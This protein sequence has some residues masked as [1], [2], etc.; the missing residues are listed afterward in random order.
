MAGESILPKKMNSMLEQSGQ[1]SLKRVLGLRHL[2][3]YGIAFMTPI[4]PAYIY[5]YVSSM[6]GGMMALA[7]CV[8]MVA[9]LFTASSYGKMSAAFPS[10]GSTYSYTQ[11]AL[12]PDIGFMAGWAMY[13]DY[14]LV[15]L[16]VLMMGATYANTLL[17]FIPYQIWVLILAA[18]VFT[19]NFRGIGF[20][21]KANNI[22]VIYMGAIV[23]V[24]VLLGIKALI[25]G[26]GAATLISAKPF[27]N[28]GTFTTSAIVSGAALASFSFLGFDSITTLS[29]EAIRPKK[30]IGRAAMLSCLIGGLIFIIQVYIAQLVWPDYNAFHSV[31][32]AFFEIVELVGGSIFSIFFTAAIIVS[33]LSAGLTGQAS[34]ARVMYAM[35]RD[36]MLP[37]KFFS[38]LHPK[39]STP[40]YN[41]FLMS[42]IGVVG[43][44][45]LPLN[46]VAELMNFGALLGFIF[47][48]LSVIVYFFFK[49]KERDWI[50]NLIIPALG[51]IICAYL[52]L[53]L[54]GLTLKV[55]FIWLTLGLIYVIFITKGFKK[56]P[57]IYKE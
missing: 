45:L 35:G 39:Y 11:K 30:D 20:T 49:M 55:G 50:R 14:V 43:A 52:W 12:A 51:L 54:S 28:A 48:N 42:L 22:L 7:Y 5:G 44:M 3:I 8:A 13:M 46:L 24:F 29:E 15:P 19:V 41:I 27:F 18:I 16:I 47:V 33:T 10:G 25:N 1:Q 56:N 40:T 21:A 32:A 31:D 4:A 34:A 53:N 23:L 2:V 26:T 9:M 36:E 57:T 6:T 37:K 17:P 38:Y